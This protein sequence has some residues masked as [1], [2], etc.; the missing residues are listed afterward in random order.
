MKRVR[1]VG[2]GLS[3]LAAAWYL[4]KLGA[5]VEIVEASSRAGGLIG[6]RREAEGLVETAANALLWTG[7]VR[8]LF[9]ELG[10]EP[11]FPRPESRRRYIVRDG[12]PRRWP[13][14]SL[15]TAVAA[16]RFARHWASR[17][18][19]P[20]AAESVA[21][22]GHRTLGAAATQ[23]LLEP[24]L[25]GIYAAPS[26]Q[27]SADAIGLGRRRHRPGLAAPRTG[28]GG[29]IDG[30]Q[31]ALLRR[32]V[33]VQFDARVDRI[34][35][36]VSTMICTSA[37]EAARL[38]HSAGLESLADA[39][40]AVR[41][42]PL[43]TATAFFE[44]SP[45]DVR[46]FG[47]LFPRG[48]ARALGVL[49]N[50][51]TFEDRSTARSETWIYGEREALEDDDAAIRSS[52]E[53]DRH[54]NRIGSGALLSLHVTRVRSALPL[55]DRAIAGARGACDALPA[56]LGLCGNYAGAIGAAALITRAR[57]EAQRLVLLDRPNWSD[58]S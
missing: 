8:E 31:T 23:H 7:D 10:I 24:A 35:P 3:G 37:P 53:R 46:G 30:L 34:E 47:V 19:A 58:I 27:L 20:T 26:G 18:L 40:R 9:A 14:S 57:R 36:A 56:W 12:V 17:T 6:T 5:D 16:A 51:D 41:M 1:V 33:R 15:E 45:D 50:T 43:V 28:M 21:A 48:S 11:Q 2:A 13:L 42:L 32:G 44:P 29:L 52:I 22:W 49:L 55:Y 25:Q 4:A 38:A 39:L 54:A